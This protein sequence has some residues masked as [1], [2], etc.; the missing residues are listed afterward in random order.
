MKS[1]KEAIPKIRIE[2][3]G[4]LDQDGTTGDGEKWTDFRYILEEKE[5]ELAGRYDVVVWKELLLQ[6][7]VIL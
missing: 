6:G 5:T 2:D 7:F 3:D 1:N 4:S